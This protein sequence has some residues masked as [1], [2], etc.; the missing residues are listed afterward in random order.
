MSEGGDVKVHIAQFFNAVDKL[1]F[2]DVWING[3][4]LSI[5]LLYSLPSSFENFRCAIESRD[6]LPNVEQLKV[7][8]EYEARNQVTVNE[9]GAMLAHHSKHNPN[10][11]FG[12]NSSMSRNETNAKASS[13]PKYKC[14]FC[15]IAGH[16]YAD[17]R[18]RMKQEAEK[19]NNT[20]MESFFAEVA[21]Y[22]SPDPT[23][24]TEANQ[25]CLDSECTFY[26]CKDARM[27]TS[28]VRTR[29]DIR[30][31]NNATSVVNAKRDVKLLTSI[32]NKTKRIRLENILH[33]P[34]LRTNLLSVAKIVDKGYQVVF[35]PNRA[36]V[37]DHKGNIKLTA[38][39]QG[40]LYILKG[41]TEHANTATQRKC[42][43]TEMWHQRFGHLN[44][45]ELLHMSK[46]Q[47][48]S[49]FKLKN[50]SEVSNCEICITQ[51][52]TN[53]P[54]SSRVHRSQHR[55]EIIYSDLCAPMQTSS[56]R[57][58]RYFMTLIDDHSR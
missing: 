18:K 11:K 4:L 17:C 40:D 37:R 57:G 48:V 29:S 56:I 15:K 43:E 1:E 14:S 5:M 52:L 33:V 13:R 7:V 21:Q 19:A 9:S 53:F 58:A 26:V 55:L 30:L 41:S 2:M 36:S 34:D 12:K 39:R 50:N 42:S 6:A 28:S 54:F 47:A 31:A 45:R 16:K 38:D 44:L 49:G 32:D 27:L 51:K 22:T 25:W 46:T 35:G 3:D 8:E 20:E 24:G 10:S 23:R